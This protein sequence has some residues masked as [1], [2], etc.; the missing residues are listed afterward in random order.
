V[1]S[2]QVIAVSGSKD[3]PA[4]L[5]RLCVKG[6]TLHET[7]SLEG[8]LLFPHVN[9]KR[10]EWD[11]ALNKVAKGFSE[12]IEKYGPDSVAFYL[13][14]QL[15]T[16]DYYVANKLMKG[17]IGSANVDTNSRL[18]M[19]SAVVGYKRAFGADAVPC[20][21][22]DLENC[23][24]LILI[25]SNAAWTHPVLYQRM[26]AAKEKRPQ[27]RVVVVDPRRTTSCDLADLHLAISPGS[28]AA[29]F[30]GLLNHLS[31][32]DSLDQDYIEQHTLGFEK[33]LEAVQPWSLDTTA[34]FCGVP[35]EDL[36]TFY[37][38]FTET[39]KTI[40]F[41]SQGINQSSSGTDKCNAIIN[42]HLATG[43]IGKEGMGPFS[44]TGQPNAM[45]GREVGGLANQLAAHMGFDEESIDRV[46]RFW[47]S[48][49]VAQKP[50]L[51]A[52]DLFDAIDEGKV[53]AVWVM[54]TNPAVS[55]PNADKV[56]RALEKCDLVVVSDCVD[57]TDTLDLAHIKLPALGWSEK[58]GTVTNSERRISR[59]PALRPATGEAKDDW[60]AICEVA[61]RMGWTEEFSYRNARDVFIEHAKLSAFENE[62]SRAFNISGLTELDN[63]QYHNLEP[64]QWP[65]LHSDSSSFTG[66]E[67]L[68]T[69]GKFYTPSGKANFVAIHPESPK[70]KTTT[71]KP[72]ILNTGRIR[73]QWH[74]MTRTG[75]A[76]RLGNHIDSPFVSIHPEDAS[77]YG[78]K[79]DQLVEISNQH[80]TFIGRAL[81]DDGLARKNLFSPI[82]WTAQNAFKGRVGAVV[83]PDTDPYSGQPEMKQT[84]VSLKPLEFNKT[85]VL[86]SNQLIDTLPAEYWV[87]NP[88]G[89]KNG[90]SAYR[91]SMAMNEDFSP[92]TWLQNQYGEQVSLMEYV[93]ATTGTERLV[94]MES[95]KI[96]AMMFVQ[97]P[98]E[99][100]PSTEW[101]NQA[102]ASASNDPIMLLSGQVSSAEDKGKLIC[103]CFEVGEK[104]IQQA[105]KEG[106][107]SVEML[108]KKL[109]CGTNCGSC[110][111]EL[112]G[113]LT[114]K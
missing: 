57:R 17:F 41:Y 5:G 64:I 105:I 13:S 25:G 91:Y 102:L 95:D 96:I 31:A 106:C 56:K 23:D 61:K 69:D 71:D 3:H 29:L 68:F 45:G 58:D 26:V 37:Q 70:S 22:E 51:L 63:Q 48:D 43:R 92:R 8:R 19:A 103:S 93:D 36:E 20:N 78:L 60:W 104:Q 79:P 62:G 34:E 100:L 110:I 90:I 32:S 52:V 33:A 9:G 1:D 46:G 109:K 42:T 87:K 21:Y 47:G 82:H 83:S 85:A 15:L 111:P 35:K 16:E 66:T 24:L 107:D 101:F 18:C 55:L 98:D 2:S 67:R 74:T 12:T 112:K 50:G 10:V 99:K 81:L 27:M 97:S 75:K 72:F 40:S 49:N 11:E 4:N 7:L 53:K 76:E 30:N 38:W 89:H 14:G 114:A 94:A 28:D 65:V 59:Q 77:E 80:G 73:D 84:A 39:E 108:G 88:I 113:F 44:I 6:S 86:V 54:A